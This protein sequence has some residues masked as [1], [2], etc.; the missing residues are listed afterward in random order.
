MYLVPSPRGSV[1]PRSAAG[2]WK[3]P[4]SN[5]TDPL[6]APDS[7]SGS[8]HVTT[9]VG[10]NS[11]ALADY[12]S[13]L[14]ADTSI[15][16]GGILGRR[17]PGGRVGRS[18]VTFL[19]P[20][21]DG[22]PPSGVTAPL[23]DRP[24]AATLKAERAVPMTV[25]ASASLPRRRHEV[26]P[27]T[28]SCPQCSPRSSP[29]SVLARA[30]AVDAAGAAAQTVRTSTAS[31]AADGGGRCRDQHAPSCVTDGRLA[32][33]SEPWPTCRATPSEWPLNNDAGN[34]GVRLQSSEDTPV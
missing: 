12:Q 8:G 19:S 4:Q 29:R 31:T 22:R 6:P 13:W 14:G 1:S 27:V 17:R 26:W 10:S 32:S 34:I 24:Y 25:T 16:R 21:R 20:V 15:G 3:T 28:A 30:D 33:S 11:A 23:D 7:T 9:L 5:A 2:V 18:T